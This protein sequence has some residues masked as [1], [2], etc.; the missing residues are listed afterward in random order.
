MPKNQAIL[1]VGKDADT[2]P[3]IHTHKHFFF[4]EEVVLK[5][6]LSLQEVRHAKLMQFWTETLLLQLVW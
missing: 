1:V 3:L 4:G 6:F 2:L 5:E